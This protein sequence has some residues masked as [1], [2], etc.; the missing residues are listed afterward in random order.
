[1]GR[2]VACSSECKTF[3]NQYYLLFDAVSVKLHSANSEKLNLEGPMQTNFNNPQ[4]LQ[5]RDKRLVSFLYH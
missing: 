3:L 5:M 1:M 2:L 4:Y